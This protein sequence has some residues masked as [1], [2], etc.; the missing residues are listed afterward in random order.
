[1]PKGPLTHEKCLTKVCAICTNLIPK[2]AERGVSKEDE[3]LIIKHVNKA[4]SKESILCPQGLHHSCRQMLIRKENGR[5]YSF[6]LPDNYD[7]EIPDRDE[8]PSE[9]CNC[10]WCKLGRLAGKNFM[11]WRMDLIERYG[12]EAAGGGPDAD[13]GGGPVADAGGG[14]PLLVN[15]GH[16]DGAEDDES[17]LEE[18]EKVC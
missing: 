5:V 15:H 7:C 1:M 17:N 2:R 14:E 6:R 10:R 18:A 8:V 11:I 9:R 16:E 13:A 3:R 4:Y 12:D